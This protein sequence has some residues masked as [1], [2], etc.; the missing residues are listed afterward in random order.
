MIRQQ[1]DTSGKINLS[2]YSL[3]QISGVRRLVRAIAIEDDRPQTSMQV[4]FFLNLKSSAVAHNNLLNTMES[5]TDLESKCLFHVNKKENFVLI[6]TNIISLL[7]SSLY[8]D[9]KRAGAVSISKLQ[10][11]LH[12]IFSTLGFGP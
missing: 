9:A 6:Q 12:L 2:F 11:E 1:S 8:F 4:I 7:Y 3:M 5:I 10:S